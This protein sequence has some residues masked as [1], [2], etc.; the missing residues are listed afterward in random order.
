M[1]CPRSSLEVARPEETVLGF[2]FGAELVLLRLVKAQL[3]R[4]ILFGDARLDLLAVA[5][6]RKRHR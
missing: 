6:N 2:D 1:F 4:T 3:S 5:P